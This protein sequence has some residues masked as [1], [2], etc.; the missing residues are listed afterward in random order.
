MHNNKPKS[1]QKCRKMSSFRYCDMLMYAN[2]YML[3]FSGNIRNDL[4]GVPKREHPRVNVLI[5]NE[6]P[7]F[8][9]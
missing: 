4:V 1:R 7:D 5:S 8:K 3:M 6:H 9:T 2:Y